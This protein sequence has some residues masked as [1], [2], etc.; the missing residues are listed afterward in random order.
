MRRIGFLV[1]FQSLCFV[2]VYGQNVNSTDSTVFL[3]EVE[4]KSFVPKTRLRGDAIVT[5]IHGTV[6]EKSG[7]V[8]EML[9][10]VP[11]MMMEGEELKVI[12]KGVPVFY[13]NGRKLYDN[14]EL[15]RIRSEEILEV[16][17]INNPGAQYDATVS[18]VVRIRTRRPQGE[19][20][21]FNLTAG[22]SQDLRQADYADPSAT[23]NFNYRNKGLDVFGMVNHW[24][25]HTLQEATT[26]QH[27]YANVGNQV[28]DN[29]QKGKIVTSTAGYGMNYALGVNQVISENHSMGARLQIDHLLNN[30]S[31]LTLDQDIFNNDVFYKSLFSET[32]T[33][34]DH[35]IGYNLN[36]Y[37]NG[38][39]G[40]IGIDWNFDWGKK[41][42]EEKMDSKSDDVH[43]LS[44][45]SSNLFATKLVVSY[46]VWKGT[47]NA[48]TEMTWVR[49]DIDYVI[50]Q[51]YISD[52]H[53]KTNEDSYSVF[54]EYL[55]NFDKYGTARIGARYECVNFDYVN[56]ADAA[57]NVRDTRRG[58]YP[59]ISYSVGFGRVNLSLSYNTKTVRPNFYRLTDATT[60][61]SH[62][63]LMQ[64]NSQLRN[65]I[66][67]EL[68]LN[69]RWSWLMASVSYTKNNHMMTQWSYPYI[70]EQVPVEEGVQVVRMI[71]LAKPVKTLV[72]FI[73]ASPTIGIY[74]MNTTV[75]CQK[76]FFTLEVD[77]PREA[78]G[79]RTKSY[80]D[81]V[82]FIN[83]NNT[84]RLPHNWQVECSLNC[85]SKGNLQ[86]YRL[87][88]WNT[89]L[90]AAIQ[91]T[92]LRNNALT[93]RLSAN[94]ILYR[95]GQDIL[96][97]SGDNVMY[98][99]NRH[100]SQ[101]LVFS[102]RYAFN[103]TKS[104]YKGTGAGG[105]AKNRM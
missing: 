52:S 50:N 99:C 98:Q 33:I 73:N 38:R 10:K 32:H 71:N 102:I 93:L 80:N 90:S 29:W 60:Y 55:A 77:D 65:Q 62:S 88:R 58:I 21:G 85:N 49:R 4:V 47:V 18:S 84:L 40:K 24:N 30:E 1:L 70:G 31:P 105:D 86:N 34:Y 66:N 5:K 51:D 56:L 35:P 6:L 67:H 89:G 23:I 68:G 57:A 2:A 36:S 63:M 94:D 22:H 25:S 79:K 11:G 12:G 83:S 15:K 3:N 46:P 20:F 92:L 45:A 87:M 74:S 104:K 54:V 59:S 76:Q 53:S 7:S 69:A 61:V 37:Y 39:W 81:P 91:K 101:R 78:S 43:S 64:G 96:L 13:V 103:Q 19:G 26:D 44:E 48:G 27:I 95:T 28:N 72:G 41:G 16:E 75:G 100:S 82:L 14:E 17:V 97:D 42:A 9:G 8:H